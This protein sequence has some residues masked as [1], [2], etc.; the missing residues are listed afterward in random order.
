MDY[1][2]RKPFP[3]DGECPRA[4]FV[5]LSERA[6]R[7]SLWEREEKWLKDHP[8]FA[9]NPG[10]T[11]DIGYPYTFNDVKRWLDKFLKERLPYFGKYEDAILEGCDW[12]Y[13][14]GLS[15]FLN[16]GMLTPSYV[17]ERLK[18]YKN[19]D[20]AS[21]EGFIRQVFGWRE[22]ARAYYVKVP[23]SVYTKNVFHASAKLPSYWY[24]PIQSKHTLIRQTITDAWNTGYLHHIRRLMVLANFMTLSNIH[25][26]GVFNWMYEFSMDS[27]DW[28]MV[29]N[30]YSMGTWSDGGYAMRKP[31]ISSSKYLQRMARMKDPEDIQMWDD[32]YSKFLKKHKDILLHTE[33]AN[34]VRNL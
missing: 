18:R 5:D 6:E 21:Y 31:Y 22:Y 4:P 34:Q 32:M 30:V 29:F 33:F 3:K 7:T 27:W 23:P 26:N 11:A 25:P 13:H 16:M 10:S 14:S 15:V 17:L 12:M 28:V 9:G 19:I 24:N 1:A 20:I 2:N 8:K